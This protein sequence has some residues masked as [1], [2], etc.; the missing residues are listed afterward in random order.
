V[1]LREIVERIERRVPGAGVAAVTPEKGDPWVNVPSARLRAVCLALGDEPELA[2]NYLRCLG[3]VDRGDRMEVVYHLVS[4]RHRHTV[5]LKVELDHNAPSVD[6]VEDVWRSANWFEREAMDLLGIQFVGHPNLT[7]LLMPPDWIGHPLRK[8]YREQPEY[9]GIATT[10]PN[11][12]GG[13]N[14]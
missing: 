7:R 3:A 12:L 5:T 1:E 9:H 14:A 4:L 6:S 13:D 2:F 11:L 8:D 10:R